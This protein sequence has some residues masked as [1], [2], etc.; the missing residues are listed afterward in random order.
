M[1]YFVNKLLSIQIKM[2]N[3]MPF[4]VMLNL[5]AQL[6][7]G[8]IEHYCKTHPQCCWVFQ[9]GNLTTRVAIDFVIWT[10]DIHGNW[11]IETSETI[12]IRIKWKSIAEL[13]SK[14]NALQTLLASK[15]TRIPFK[16]DE[17]IIDDQKLEDAA[18]HINQ[19][20][21][22][23]DLFNKV[24]TIAKYERIIDLLQYQKNIDSE[25]DILR[26]TWRYDVEWPSGKFDQQSRLIQ[27]IKNLLDIKQLDLE[28]SI[29][30]YNIPRDLAKK[31]IHNNER[32]SCHDPNIFF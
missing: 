18:E 6:E 27:E 29:Q 28:D 25:L 8:D 3:K 9:Q 5:F 32:I 17:V 22:F 23:A 26:C 16:Y 15:D 20:T 7:I 19:N 30:Y 11:D 4:D 24:W 12:I 14:I 10:I 13:Q 1:R 21:L 2:S 31:I